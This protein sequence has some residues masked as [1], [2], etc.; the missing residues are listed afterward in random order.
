MHRHMMAGVTLAAAL[1]AM[2]SGSARAQDFTATLSGFNEVGAL[3]A[4]TGAILSDAS[5]TLKA[6]LDNTA[7]TLTYTF[8]YSATTSNINQAHIHFGK[9]HTPGG[10]IVFLCTNLNNGPAAA[11]PPLCP[12]GPAT[13][14]GTVSAA[15]VV[16]PGAQGITAGN[17]DGLED[18]LNSNT[19]Y[20]NL[21]T[22]AFPAGEVRG[23]VRRADKDGDDDKH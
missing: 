3:N 12:P 7:M 22:V 13:V 4:E 5:A 1:F 17:F 6:H 2:S 11:T 9:A 14:T 10:V 19:A 21:H 20:A 15:S 18:A 16:G 23:Q 8:S